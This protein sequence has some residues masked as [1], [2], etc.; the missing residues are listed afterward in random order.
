MKS[1]GLE[2][3]LPHNS[4]TS[5][6]LNAPG[7][8]KLARPARRKN[9]NSSEENQKNIR[10]SE[11]K[12]DGKNSRGPSFGF[13]EIPELPYAA[14][15]VVK[16]RAIKKV[17]AGST[18]EKEVAKQSWYI[19]FFFHNAAEDRMERIRVTRKLN[20]IKDPRQKLRNFNNLCEAY[21]IAL[22]GGWNPLDEHANARL[23]KE[24]I[25]IN[26]KEAL[27]LF[28]SYHKAKGTRPKSISTYRSTVKSFIKYHGGDKKVSTISDFEI[29]DFLN[30]KERD[31]KVIMDWLDNHDKY[32]Q[33]FVCMIYYT[34][35][36]PKEP[37]HLQLKHIDL[38]KNIIVVPAGIAKNKK[39]L[40]V[41]IDT[42]LRTEIDLLN[43]DEY[44]KD[45]SGSTHPIRPC[46]CNSLLCFKLPDLHHL[47]VSMSV[48]KGKT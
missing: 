33:L 28:E 13:M 7:A 14:P 12:S 42:S 46:Q 1:N 29:T 5:L 35:I 30:S 10:Y 15:R 19:E 6:P 41:N 34:C 26:L 40:P 48:Y 43:L 24:L 16:G 17:P 18:M 8:K 3:F 4:D 37:H 31:F 45:Y 2:D 36:R 20:R 32:C 9:Q 38:E 23:K 47:F 11:R 27:V 39:S 21:R 22:E 44:P 25:G